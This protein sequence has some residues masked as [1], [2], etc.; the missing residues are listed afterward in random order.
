MLTLSTLTLA[1]PDCEVGRLARGL[2][3]SDAFVTHA[4]YA[5]LPFVVCGA[6]VR[7]IA[8]RLDR[9]ASPPGRPS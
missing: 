9:P 6:I 4:W 7:A 5:V 1:C 3:V 8:R 2:V